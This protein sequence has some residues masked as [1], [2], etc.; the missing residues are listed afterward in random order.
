MSSTL[1]FSLVYSKNVPHLTT[2]LLCCGSKNLA[3]RESLAVVSTI[4]LDR[5]TLP[6]FTPWGHALLTERMKLSFSIHV[7]ELLVAC[8]WEGDIHSDTADCPV[9]SMGN[10]CMNCF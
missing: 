7:T 6:L 9:G 10:S 1:Q 5:I 4:D 2:G 8:V 3:S